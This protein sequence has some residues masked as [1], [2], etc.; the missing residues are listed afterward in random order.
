LTSATTRNWA[1][2]R[3]PRSPRSSRVWAASTRPISAPITDNSA[4]VFNFNTNQ[5]FS[6]E[7][8]GTGTLEKRGTG[9]L[10]LASGTTVTRSNAISGGG[11]ITQL[12]PG[13]TVL[14]GTNTYQGGTTFSGGTLQISSNAN[15]GAASGP[16]TFDGGTLSVRGAAGTMVNATRVTTFNGPATFDVAA[17]NT[18]TLNEVISGSGSLTKTDAGV[19][20]LNGDNSYAGLTTVGAGTMF[21][22]G[23]SSAARR[24]ISVGSTGTLAGT[25][26][27]GGDVS[28]AGGGTLTPGG[29]GGT[30]GTLTINGNLSLSS[31]SVLNYTY[32][33]FGGVPRND[34]TDV[35]GHLTLNGILNVSAFPGGTFGAGIYRILECIDRQHLMDRRGREGERPLESRRICDL[36]DDGRDRNGRRRYRWPGHLQRRSVRCGRLHHRRRAA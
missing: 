15:L 19:L 13:T 1:P 6:G 28:I 32:G 12:G 11:A 27:I 3:T 25:G 18:L 9:N 8:S 4:L 5:T 20:V 10:T 29:V 35:K 24:P 7:I 14:T 22:N 31:G 23:D 30:T 17:G 16:L 34:L 26:I 36:P 21:V 33:T 2:R